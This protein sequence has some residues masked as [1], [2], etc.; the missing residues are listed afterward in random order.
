MTAYL[1]DKNNTQNLSRERV[2]AYFT[3]FPDEESTIARSHVDAALEKYTVPVEF[4]QQIY[5]Q[6]S[7]VFLGMPVK[8]TSSVAMRKKNIDGIP[9]A[10]AMAHAH[11][12]P[13]G[14]LFSRGDLRFMLNIERHSSQTRLFCLVSGERNY[15]AVLASDALQKPRAELELEIPEDKRL[16]YL[17]NTKEYLTELALRVEKHKIGIYVAESDGNSF[18]RLV[19]PDAFCELIYS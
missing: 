11:N 9:D 12:H 6:D 4:S 2:I 8:G 19:S 17:R 3:E 15:F 18:R 5:R 10:L 16:D 1:D 13:D 7:G 14:T